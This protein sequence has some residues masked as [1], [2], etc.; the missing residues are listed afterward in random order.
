MD[1]TNL[2]FKFATNI[3]V[4]EMRLTEYHQIVANNIAS[5]KET[6]FSMVE[7]NVRSTIE[8]M[9]A[10]ETLSLKL[11]SS[12]KVYRSVPAKANKEYAKVLY[13]FLKDKDYKENGSE[14]TVES[15][16]TIP[17]LKQ[18]EKTVIEF[19]SC[20]EIKECISATVIEAISEKEIAKSSIKGLLKNTQNDVRNEIGRQIVKYST[21]DVRNE[22]VSNVSSSIT[23]FMHSGFMSQLSHT[24]GGVM[25]TGAGKIVAS[26]IAVALSKAISAS[27]L[28]AALTTVVKKIGIKAM[29]K[30]SVSKGLA[31]LLPLAGFP[32]EAVLYAAI[33]AA[34][35]AILLYE[36][37]TFPKKLAKKVPIQVADELRKNFDQLNSDITWEI[38]KTMEKDIDFDENTD[39]P[40]QSK[41]WLFVFIAIIIAVVVLLCLF[42]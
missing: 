17:I 33:V 13:C 18:V 40:S 20:Q 30:G 7:R 19:Y 21:E 2:F 37:N 10:K 23:T 24:I 15:E 14:Y 16:V 32:I 6:L 8:K 22:V 41:K 42:M 9:S 29:I 38:L 34:I 26:K 31:I 5:Q 36:Y 27:T 39:K 35:G 11:M 3:N 4:Y 25:A 1:N 28:K 12:G